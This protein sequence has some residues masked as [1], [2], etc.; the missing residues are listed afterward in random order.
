M[1]ETETTANESAEINTSGI[2]S[3]SGGADL[4]CPAC[5]G[6]GKAEMPVTMG[7]RIKLLRE[8]RGEFRAGAAEKAGISQSLWGKIESDDSENPSLSTILAIA[9]AL[10]VKVGYLLGE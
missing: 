2:S 1:S 10:D 4:T 7:G 3:I 9:K 5:K 8:Q 6:S